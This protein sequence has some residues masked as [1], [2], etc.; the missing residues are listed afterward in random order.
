MSS[1]TMLWAYKLRK[2]TC[3]KIVVMTIHQ[4]PKKDKNLHKL[5]RFRTVLELLLEPI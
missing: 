1:Q 4:I 5:Q 2:E 3:Y